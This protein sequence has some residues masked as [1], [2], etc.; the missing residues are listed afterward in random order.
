MGNTII[1]IL[2][3]LIG[4]PVLAAVA[5]LFPSYNLP[6]FAALVVGAAAIAAREAA[7]FFP[8]ETRTY[9]GSRITI[10][11]LGA[12]PAAVGYIAESF[13]PLL[14]PETVLVTM[15]AIVVVAMVLQ[16][17]RRIDRRF[18]E[19]VPIVAMHVF[20][21]VYPGLFAWYA[22]RLVFLPYASWVV[23]LFVLSVYLNDSSAWLFGRL[24]GKKPSA[25]ELPPVSVSPN[26]SRIGFVGGFIASPAVII[27]F[28]FLMRDRITAS[29]IGA[30]ILGVIVGAAAILGDLVESALKRS[31]AVKDS[32]QIIPGRGG[33]LDSIDSPL[34]AAPFFYYGFVLV[35]L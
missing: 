31:A 30:A 14:A 35:F 18:G 9:K 8:A 17:G 27:L 16:V 29:F 6:V 32:G 11:I 19:I 13:F 26:K 28:T 24:F 3:F 4:L 10:P 12:A 2:V 5:F 20:L 23:L 21:I 25:G 15:L 7:F 33:L 34:F 22:M 1:R